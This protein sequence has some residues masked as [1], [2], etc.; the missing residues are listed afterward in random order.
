M[1]PCC[2]AARLLI[3][4]RHPRVPPA[5]G[6][7]LHRD[8][9]ARDAPERR[10]DRRG[11][12]EVNLG[13][14][15]CD[16]VGRL[17][18]VVVRDGAVDVVRHVRRPDLVV[19]PVEDAAVRP[20]DGE[21][22]AAH[23]RELVVG[24]VGHVHVG[25]LQPRVEHEPRVREEVRR[26]VQHRQPRA[27]NLRG[28]QAE[29]AEHGADAEVGAP[30]LE[31]PGGGP[32]VGVERLDR[33]KVVR[34]AVLWPAGGAPQQVRGPAEDE[35]EHELQRA[36]RPLAQL[37]RLFEVVLAA[38]VLDALPAVDDKGHVRLALGDVV[39]VR[40][41]DGV[42]ALPAEV[43]HEQQRVEKVADRVLQLQV[44]G[45][46]L[47]AALVCDDP[48]ARPHRARDGRVRQ[49]QRRKG[50]LHR[51]KRPCPKARRRLRDRNGRVHH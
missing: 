38:A 40:V 17:A 15:L 19:Q 26:P 33:H 10:V 8:A 22:C 13:E 46:G 21:E 18:R 41:V 34:R 30:N 2:K 23:V 3:A 44:V 29:D 16:G 28:D 1:R 20:V 36:P 50:R 27:A 4:Y 31:R 9:V 51:D 24:E 43:R 48:H 7:Q 45:E 35:V 14:G 37:L 39:R 49:P 6:L 25:V 47:V 12:V 42:R 11:V 32:Q 5:K